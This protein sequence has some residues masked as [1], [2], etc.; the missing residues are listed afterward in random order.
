MLD[1]YNGTVFRE[2]RITAKPVRPAQTARQI[3]I[4]D[5]HPLYARA[6]MQAL[7]DALPTARIDTATDFDTLS[8]R[9]RR[10]DNPILIVN[11]AIAGSPG[12][13]TA[14]A[15]RQ[16]FPKAMI[17]L[18]TEIVDTGLEAF[19]R[20][21]GAAVLVSKSA[22][23][24]VFVDLIAGRGLPKTEDEPDEEQAYSAHLDID[25]DIYGEISRLPPKQLAVFR[26]MR[27]GHLNKEIAYQLGLSE[28]TVKHHVSVILK[29]L[30]YYRRTQLVALANRLWPSL[31]LPTT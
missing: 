14:A 8:A 18:V 7:E 30:G 10:S 17:I 24:D 23:A 19:M 5:P 26:E 16:S 25:E 6:M 4:A 11:P 29:K 13:T 28:A 9:A 20:D 22:D 2:D 1:G 31:A 12:L 15:L 27:F 21:N 3:V